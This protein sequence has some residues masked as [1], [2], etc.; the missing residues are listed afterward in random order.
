MFFFGHFGPKRD[1]L[2]ILSLKY[3]EKVINSSFEV[4]LETKYSHFCLNFRAHAEFS[5]FGYLGQKQNFL[6]ILSFML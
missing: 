5:Y 1:F 2:N 4:Y 6:D 3:D